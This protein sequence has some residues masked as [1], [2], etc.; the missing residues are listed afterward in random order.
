MNKIIVWMQSSMDG[1][2][3]GPNDGFDWPQVGDELHSHFV[4]TLRD[5][6]LFVY[7]HNVFDMMSG[8]WPIADTLPGST[9]NQAEFSRIWRPMPKVV[10]SRT[11]ASADWNADV[12]PDVGG[13][14]EL[15]DAAGGDAYVFGGPRTVAA[16]AEADLVDEY[17]VF[18]HPVVLGGGTRFF[19]SLTNRQAMGLVEVRTFDGRVAGLRHARERAA[20]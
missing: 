17:Q 8:Y 7:G 11:L 1:F 14:R 6:G 19:P 10:V 12:L 3:T 9:H 18:I 15:V 5:A 13:L 16:L 20:Q 2:A 4:A